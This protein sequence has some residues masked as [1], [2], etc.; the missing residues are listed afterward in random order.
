[1]RL[2]AA[3]IACCFISYTPAFAGDFKDCMKQFKVPAKTFEQGMKNIDHCMNVV[4]L[5]PANPRPMSPERKAEW[6]SSM[7]IPSTERYRDS[8]EYKDY[9]FKAWEADQD[10]KREVESIN[11]DYNLRRSGVLP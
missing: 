7:G 2:I 1:M 10:Y 5:H 3:L 11:R 9:E 6:L 8:Q 4:V